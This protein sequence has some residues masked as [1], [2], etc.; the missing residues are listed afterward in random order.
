MTIIKKNTVGDST[1]IDDISNSSTTKT[2]SIDKIKQQISNA[3][4]SAGSGETSPHQTYI[5]ELSRWGIVQGIPAKPYLDSDYI[6]ADANIQ[7]F[8]NAIQWAYEEG[9]RYIIVPQGSYS[10]CYPRSILI[11]KNNMT[12][13]G[14][15]STFKVIYDSDKRSPLDT[16]SDAT[17]ANAY[18]WPSVGLPAFTFL[19]ENAYNS[20]I[21][22]C[23]M[24]GCRAD[25][26]FTNTAERAI[27]WTQGIIFSKSTNYCSVRYCNISFYMGDSIAF[28]NKSNMEY[29]EFSV[30]PTLNDL[31][32]TNGQ[33]V[34]STTNMVSKMLT[35]PT[36]TQFHVHN[37]FQ[38]SS[39][40]FNRPT[41]ILTK[42]VSVYYYRTDNSFITSIHN[43]KIYK[44]MTIPE[45]ATKYRFVF[46]NETDTTKTQSGQWGIHL[47]F[48]LNPHHNFI[49][50]NEIYGNHRGGI[51]PG[52]N[53]NVIQYNIIH[54]IGTALLGGLDIYGKPL[55][56]DPT[57]YAINQ[58]DSYGDSTIIRSNLIYGCY[59]GILCGSYS[60]LIEN[61]YIYDAKGWGINLYTMVKGIVKGNFI[62]KCTNT[63]GL[64]NAHFANAH[65][66]ISGNTLVGGN[67]S[68]TGEDSS[69]HLI[70]T[71]NIII[72]PANVFVG[73]LDTHVFRNN[74]FKFNSFYSGTSA[75][76]IN[77]LE[78]CTFDVRGTSPKEVTLKTNEVI[79]CVFN[80]L[81]LRLSGRNQ[82]TAREKPIFQDC[83][84]TNCVWDVRVNINQTTIEVSKSKLVDTILKVENLNVAG[85]HPTILLKDS[86]VFVNNNTYLFESSVN[87][88]AGYGIIQLERCNLQI[89]NSGFL[90]LIKNGY[91]VVQKT[92]I[93]SLK[94]CKALYT[95]A[96][97]L[98]LL[99]YSHKTTMISFI[100]ARNIFT[101]IDL[102]ARDAGYFIGYDPL[103]QSLAEPASGVFFVGDVR[104]NPSLT[105]G[106]TKAWICISS[107][108]VPDD[109]PR[110][111]N[112]I[113]PS[114]STAKVKGDQVNA[115]GHVYECITAGTTGSSAP[116]WLTTSGSL[117]NDG[118]VTWQEI[119][120]LAEFRAD[121][122]IA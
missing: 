78:G 39:A 27:E 49:E 37:V 93:L 116:T 81:N 91:T 44:P 2:W 28:F 83:K 56:N 24:I 117:V 42:D 54:D 103:F 18:A 5:I 58:E 11:N 109:L 87:N 57:M 67:T 85:E 16:R 122:T 84:F 70:M 95:G 110:I 96:S 8:N 107:A 15:G 90:Y 86:D 31:D 112:K 40:G 4:S 120:Y 59:D 98:N 72:D 61:N 9:F 76:T 80:Y 104:T 75:I 74:H 111:A 82:T 68:W 45:G 73:A 119:G 23:K 69:Y 43:Q 35:I 79:G 100:S 60:A 115:S 50:H 64:M 113:N 48:G 52:G 63:I 51:Q 108:G 38:I 22:N 99:Y 13:D 101:N 118:T 89:S 55:F 41:N 94:E 47:K 3:G 19:V 10:V 92:C 65:I 114:T 29:A 121:G 46:Y 30:D 106:S 20:H 105:T 26:S 33:L 21:I 12:F 71:D 62:W 32:K 14:N 17:D 53:N 25:R 34:A 88:T 102:P 1:T 66:E 7:G 77:R 36:S 6:A 97:R